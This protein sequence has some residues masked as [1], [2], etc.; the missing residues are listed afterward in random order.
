MKRL[1]AIELQKI[2]KNRASRILTISYFVLLSLI[3][4]IA[5]IKFDF[6]VVKIHFAEQGI[7]NFP[8]IWHFNSF[9][10]V[11]GKTF[12][13]IIIV[14]MI[15]NEYSYGTLKQNLIDGMTKKEFILSKL[16]ASI[17]FAL[18]S[19]TFVFL[20]SLILGLIYSSYTEVDIIFSEM[21]YLLAYFVSLLCFS[22]I[23]IFA[24]ILIKRSAF[25]LGFI[26]LWLMLEIVL[27]HFRIGFPEVLKGFLPMEAMSRLLIEPISRLSAIKAFGKLAGVKEVKDYA[28][29]FLTVLIAL[30][31]TAI[32]IF[33]SYKI[34]QKRDL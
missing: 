13:G 28:V 4:L 29:H 15:S 14:S 27:V 2:W 16:Y 23:C 12:L 1:L 18:I 10:A 21:E 24:G 32:F 22:S 26:G 33:S 20:V 3:A 31:W 6:G 8:F 9:V 17:L 7:F 5:T 25:A 30:I 19:T 34:I 11:Y